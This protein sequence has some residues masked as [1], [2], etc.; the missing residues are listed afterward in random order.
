MSQLDDIIPPEISGDE[1]YF[2]IQRLARE[3]NLKNV[4]E[5]G[6]SAGGG[7]TE[8]FVNGLQGNSAKPNLYCLE[9]SKPRFEQLRDRYKRFEFV[10]PYNASSVPVS[11]FMSETEVRAFYTGTYTKLN[12]YPLQQIL[13][14][15]KQ[16]IDYVM[17]YLSKIVEELRNISKVV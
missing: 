15:L 12:T 14:W 9:V 1:F 7:S 3:E 17:K 11:A 2:Y 5:I 10:K 6:S 4:L 8:A 13:G 16:D